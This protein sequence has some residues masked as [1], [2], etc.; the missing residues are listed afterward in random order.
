[1]NT[2]KKLS[3]ALGITQKKD[4]IILPNPISPPITID[5]V[6][7]TSLVVAESNLPALPLPVEDLIVQDDF[8][9]ARKNIREIIEQGQEALQDLKNVA[10]E[11]ESPRA[12]EVLAGL[13]KNLVE[14]NKELLALSKAKKDIKQVGQ[15]RQSGEFGEQP[16][17][18]VEN[19]VFVGSTMDLDAFIESRR[20]GKTT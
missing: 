10:E 13:A 3:E 7:N 9:F 14:A 2:D 4:R 19:A 5:Q 1:M 6:G 20:N 8:D 11:S 12:Y 15:G 18:A 16:S 17:I